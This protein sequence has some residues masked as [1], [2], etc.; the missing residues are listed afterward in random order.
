MS[1]QSALWRAPFTY[2]REA[3]ARW[4]DMLHE[5]APPSENV[6]WLHCAWMAGERR[7]RPDGTWD[8]QPVQRWVVWEMVPYR[9]LYYD[10]H[11]AKKR[12]DDDLILSALLDA[13]PRQLGKWV[14]GR[15]RDG[16]TFK[17]G[18]W[19][20]KS[21]ATVSMQQWELF[22]EFRGYA[23][24]TW[25]LQGTQG[26]TARR[27]PEWI[28]MFAALHKLPADPPEPGAL[29]YAEMDW[30]VIEQLANRDK[31]RRWDETE[32]R[33]FLERT[34]RDVR[35][36]R[37]AG[38][39]DLRWRLLK[40]IHAQCD[41]AADAMMPAWSPSDLPKGDTHY[42]RDEDDVERSFIEDTPTS[43]DA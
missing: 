39:Q 29:E 12:G 28:R 37:V 25:I 23:I 40:Y 26:G 43:I 30:R 17:D 7:Q 38:E 5:L 6:P 27:W 19:K 34:M 10:H 31:L 15:V 35:A 20:W 16:R 32:T 42:N 33:S 8:L 2:H 3:P 4:Q 9:T 11:R 18:E 13:H 14:R 36:E 41:A 24:P 22:R 1:T 21:F